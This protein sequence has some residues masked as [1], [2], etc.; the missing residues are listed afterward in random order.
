MLFEIKGVSKSNGVFLQF[1]KLIEVR[2]TGFGPKL[3]SHR[4]NMVQ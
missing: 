2:F 3:T 1:E 4:L